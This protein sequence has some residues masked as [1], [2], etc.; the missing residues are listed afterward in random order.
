MVKNVYREQVCLNGIK[1]SKK[2]ES[3][4]KTTNGKVVLQLPEQKNQRNLFKSVW[5]KIELLS[6]RMLEEM[7]GINR[8]TVHNIL[9]KDMKKKKV[10]PSFVPHLLM[11][12]QKHE[13]TASSVEFDEMTDDDRNV[14]KGL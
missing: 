4:Y 7:T 9:V 1:V 5:P 14:F 3:H 10:R 11:P 12:D 6:V 2:S 8:E 13:G